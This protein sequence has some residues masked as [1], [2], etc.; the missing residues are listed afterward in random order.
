MQ[1][2]DASLV[3]TIFY[4]IDRRLSIEAVCV[5]V[6]DWVYVCLEVCVRV[7]V[8]VDHELNNNNSE[9]EVGVAEGES[10]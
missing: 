7:C 5:C 2:G 3:L 8:W 10:K 1:R 9:A 6:C 4:A